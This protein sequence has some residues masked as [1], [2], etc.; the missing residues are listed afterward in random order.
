MESSRPPPP[1]CQDG[2]LESA[3][4][5]G[6]D[7]RVRL[8]RP[9]RLPATNPVPVR[10]AASPFPPPGL[11]DSPKGTTMAEAEWLAC[12]EP[13]P[14]LESLGT[15]ANIR[16]LRLF[17]CRRQRAAGLLTED[18]VR[19]AGTRSPSS[20]G[21]WRGKQPTG[22]WR[23]LG[24]ASMAT[25][26]SRHAIAHP[27]EADYYAISAAA[28]AVDSIRRNELA[29]PSFA[30]DAVAYDALARSGSPA[31][32]RISTEWT[33]RFRPRAFSQDALGG[34]EE[35]PGPSGRSAA[36]RI[37]GRACRRTAK[38]CAMLRDIFGNPF[39]PAT[40][41]PSGSR[42]LFEC[43]P[44]ASTLTEPSTAFQ[45]WLT[46]FRTLG[47]R[48]GTSST[49]AAERIRMSAD[50]GWWTKCSTKSDR[51]PPDYALE[52]QESNARP[53][54]SRFSWLGVPPTRSFIQLPVGGAHPTLES[55]I[56]DITFL[57]LS[58][59]T[60]RDFMH[61]LRRR[62]GVFPSPELPPR[63]L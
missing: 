47:A 53:I 9:S 27:G 62:L 20:S 55:I 58:N 15:A 56:L 50:V 51:R 54:G 28:D 60:F 2:L 35:G 31:L 11:G 3:G 33:R 52:S 5:R 40:L 6:V 43:A 30:A 34:G 63:L 1:R 48:T 49:I 38:Q 4:C 29:T 19:H 36:P 57:T 23:T 45:F 14:M 37:H 42:T 16:K 32:A 24:L 10:I 22:T 13:T 59:C 21:I 44:K 7:D 12:D 41:H 61:F 26:W 17:C 46:P 25:R 39:R 8:G 18:Y